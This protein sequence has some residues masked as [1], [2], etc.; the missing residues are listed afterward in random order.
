MGGWVSFSSVE[1]VGST[2]TFGIELVDW[3]EV[4]RPL[5]KSR[6][7]QIDSQLDLNKVA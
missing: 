6:S 5:I 1:N 7:I 2:F 4:D 3:K